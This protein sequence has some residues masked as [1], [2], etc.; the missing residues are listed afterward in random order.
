M[1]AWKSPGFGG[2]LTSEFKLSFALLWFYDIQVYKVFKSV[3]S[4]AI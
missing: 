4:S 3:F 1:E 2:R